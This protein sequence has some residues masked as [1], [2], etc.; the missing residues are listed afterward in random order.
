MTTELD[1]L[2]QPLA[3]YNYLFEQVHASTF[4]DKLAAAGIAPANQ[5]EVEE[6]FRL[7]GELRQYTQEKQASSGSRFSTAV[8][9]LC[10]VTGTSAQVSRLQQEQ[11]VKQAA[12]SLLQD[13]TIY[14][15]LLSLHLHDVALT[16][17]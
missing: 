8:A 3:A 14:D 11:A 9:D 4:L 15:S 7:A 16:Q 12:A 17:G 6:L 10:A 1:K 13:K 5:Q 2:P